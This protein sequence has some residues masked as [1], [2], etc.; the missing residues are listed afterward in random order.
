MSSQPEKVGE[1]KVLPGMTTRAKSQQPLISNLFNSHQNLPKKIR[2]FPDSRV[3][4][5]PWETRPYAIAKASAP[6]KIIN[7]H[8][9]GQRLASPE[10]ASKHMLYSSR[11][12][13]NEDKLK[14]KVTE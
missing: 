8:R 1:D 11:E 3:V 7:P 14:R 5:D 10:K 13:E 2:T 12:D 6:P 9:R 4:C